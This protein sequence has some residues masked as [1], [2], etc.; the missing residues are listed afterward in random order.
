MVLKKGF[1]KIFFLNLFA[2]LNLLNLASLD[3][4]TNIVTQ[5]TSQKKNFFLALIHNLDKK[6]S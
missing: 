6:V 2:I 1:I 4:A 3:F 5:I